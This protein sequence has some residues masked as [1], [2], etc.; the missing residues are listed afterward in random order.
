MCESF[1]CSCHKLVLQ[2]EMRDHGQQ[3]THSL[4]LSQIPLSNSAQAPVALLSLIHTSKLLPQAFLPACLL[5]RLEPSSSCLVP[6]F[7]LFKS[8]PCVLRT[9]AVCWGPHLSCP[10]LFSTHSFSPHLCTVGHSTG[11]TSYFRLFSFINDTLREQRARL[12]C[13]LLCP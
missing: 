11:S 6:F 13:S 4:L 12:F 7:I 5:N 2:A 9:G 1:F 10:L 8:P 3:Q